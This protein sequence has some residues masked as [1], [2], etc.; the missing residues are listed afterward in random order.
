MSSEIRSTHAPELE[1]LLTKLKGFHVDRKPGPDL[2]KPSIFAEPSCS[3]SPSM[4]LAVFLFATV[5]LSA[6]AQW[7]TTIAFP[8]AGVFVRSGSS[9]NSLRIPYDPMF[10][11]NNPY[12]AF[13]VFHPNTPGHRSP[14][15]LYLLQKD[16]T[17]IC[18]DC[19]AASRSSLVARERRAWLRTNS[20]PTTGFS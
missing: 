8:P 4:M 2:G 13:S 7:Y 9:L 14:V 1:T 20:S 11:V 5:F 16:R 10:N 15:C 6:H 18:S 12:N 17:G 3:C 19:A